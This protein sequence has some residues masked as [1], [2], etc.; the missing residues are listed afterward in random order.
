MYLNYSLYWGNMFIISM[1]L[2]DFKDLLN[3]LELDRKFRKIGMTEIL[4]TEF[5]VQML[6]SIPS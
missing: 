6:V 5:L 1:G 3:C 2:A 4:Q